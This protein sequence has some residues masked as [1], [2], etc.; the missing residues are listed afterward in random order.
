MIGFIDYLLWLPKEL[1]EKLA[2]EV[3]PKIRK[4]RGLMELYNEENTSPTILHSFAEQLDLGIAK[5]VEQGREEGKFLALVEMV[6]QLLE[7]KFGR[8]PKDIEQSI[9][10][11]DSDV[12]EGVIANIFT[13]EEMGEVRKFFGAK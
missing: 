12:L 10:K 9:S 5:G 6:S 13:I 2:G 11:A 4:E 1:T 8:I 3:G 7:G